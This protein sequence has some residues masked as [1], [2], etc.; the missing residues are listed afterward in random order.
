MS[1]TTTTRKSAGHAARRH[2]GT[3][4]GNPGRNTQLALIEAPRAWRLDEHTRE[5]GREGVARAREALRAGLR[6]HP[7]DPPGGAGG[8]GGHGTH[9]RAA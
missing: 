5:I 7:D 8:H 2:T 3:S 4:T 6:D 9:R 1:T